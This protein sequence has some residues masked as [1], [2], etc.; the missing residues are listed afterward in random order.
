MILGKGK[1]ENTS[2]LISLLTCDFKGKSDKITNIS[3]S[4][5]AF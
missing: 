1:L 4:Q 3:L 2:F 5:K